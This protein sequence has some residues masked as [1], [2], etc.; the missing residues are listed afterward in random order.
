[1]TQTQKA[2]AQGFV[3]KCAEMGVDPEALVKAAS[4]IGEGAATGATGGATLGA[5]G[6]GVTA[7]AGNSLLQHMTGTKLPLKAKLLSLL[8]NAGVGA[9]GGGVTGAA[10]GAVGSAIRGKPEPAPAPTK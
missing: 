3:E 9:V 7:A 4:G 8:L 6:G 5:I 1:M 2:Y 10:T